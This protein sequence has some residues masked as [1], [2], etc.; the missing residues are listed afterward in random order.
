[1]YHRDKRALFCDY[2]T[3]L[4]FIFRFDSRDNV[5][6]TN[7]KK[8]PEHEDSHGAAARAAAMHNQISSKVFEKENL[9]KQET[10][11]EGLVANLERLCGVKMCQL[12]G[13]QMRNGMCFNS[14]KKKSIGSLPFDGQQKVYVALNTQ[15]RCEI[16]RRNSFP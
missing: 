4:P 13:I 9:S 6:L 1:M 5:G 16:I 3:R 14:I 15:A 11:Q 7:W 12:E 10:R 8:G 2:W